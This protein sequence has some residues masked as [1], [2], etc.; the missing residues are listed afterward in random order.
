MTPRL[1]AVGRSATIEAGAADFVDACLPAPGLSAVIVG[2][3]R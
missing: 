1:I 3:W 2:E